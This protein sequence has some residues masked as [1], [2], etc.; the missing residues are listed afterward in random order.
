MK[1]ESH[2]RAGHERVRQTSFPDPAKSVGLAP[3][4]APHAPGHEVERE[5]EREPRSPKGER[6]KEPRPMKA[7][8]E[9]KQP[10]TPKLPLKERGT[11][12]PRALKGKI[13]LPPGEQAYIPED[14]E[15]P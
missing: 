14:A 4:R 10:K 9:P 3:P 12:V 1:P 7:M 15:Y 8:M 13:A 11:G 5:R 6:M 2:F